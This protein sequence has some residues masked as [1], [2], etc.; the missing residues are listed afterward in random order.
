[1]TPRARALA[2]LFFFAILAILALAALAVASDGPAPD[3]SSW[4][5]DAEGM[6]EAARRFEQEARPMF[7]YFYTDWCPYCRQFERD[8]LSADLVEDYIDGIVAVRV[9][10]ENGPAEAEISRRYGV[11]GFPML[12]MLSPGSKTWSR[13]ERIE[14]KDGR[15]VLKQPGA[16]VDTLKQASA[17]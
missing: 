8:L 7:V 17:R 4:L 1:M 16:F 9:N 6:L 11:Q 14:L 3:F 15:P 12:F 2:P 10:P 5:E 13:V